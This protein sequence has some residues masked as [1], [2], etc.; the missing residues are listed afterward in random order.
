[1]P[2]SSASNMDMKAR[3]TDGMESNTDLKDGKNHGHGHP[4]HDHLR[5]R[6]VWVKKNLIDQTAALSYCLGVSIVHLAMF[7]VL[8][9]VEK[10]HMDKIGDLSMP[11]Q[12]EAVRWDFLINFCNTTHII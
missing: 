6:I 2:G 1:M 5:R 10:P 8:F 9:M 11:C 4:A 7:L 12:L 3:P